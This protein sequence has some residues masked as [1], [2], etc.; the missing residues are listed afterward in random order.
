VLAAFW[1]CSGA[2]FRAVAVLQRQPGL[3]GHLLGLA[4]AAAAAGPLSLPALRGGEADEG[5]AAKQWAGQ[6]ATAALLAAQASALQILAAECFA[7]AAA[8]PAGAAGASGAGGSAAGMPAELAGF[9]RRLPEKLVPP[10]LERYC[11]PLPTHGLLLGV[12]RAAAAA[13]LQLLGAALSDDALWLSA[14]QGAALVPR[15]AA[16]A[17]PL[18]R[19]FASQGE[20]ARVLAEQAPR[21]AARSFPAAAAARAVSRMLLQQAEVPERVAADREPGRAF[22][23]DWQQLA[24]RLGGGAAAQ[25]LSTLRALPAWLEGTSVAASLEDARLAAAAALKALLSAAHR[26]RPTSSGDGGSDGAP[27]GAV[28]SALG[29]LCDALAD[30]SAQARARAGTHAPAAVDPAAAQLGGAAEAAFVLLL[31]AQRW[32]AGPGDE[33]AATALCTGLLQAAG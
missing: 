19:P 15:L 30:L 20:A 27:A 16:A 2:A 25:Q 17:Q 1:Q 8:P 18:L 23:Y 22:V 33:A 12:Q 10:L 32:A 3:W 28:Q 7:W 9:L 26:L 29:V 4:E 13:A 5:A 11:A 14:A 31:L 6:E 21:L 24:R